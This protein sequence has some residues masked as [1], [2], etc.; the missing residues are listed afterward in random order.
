MAD[1]VA[2]TVA[3]NAVGNAVRMHGSL[4]T[5]TTATKHLH[6]LRLSRRTRTAPEVTR[7]LLSLDRAVDTVWRACSD[8]RP[9]EVWVLIVPASRIADVAQALIGERRIARQTVGIRPG[10]KVHEIL[11]S[12]EETRRTTRTGNY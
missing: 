5:V 7:F 8:G 9:G 12:E 3:G 4:R 10:E 2:D 6:R 11:V 1:A